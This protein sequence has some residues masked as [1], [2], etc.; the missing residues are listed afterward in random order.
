VGLRIRELSNTCW[1]VVLDRVCETCGRAG[2]LCGG[3]DFSGSTREPTTQAMRE[4]KRSTAAASP[5]LRE[6]II[7]I[8]HFCRWATRTR[9]RWSYPP[10]YPL[11]MPPADHGARNASGAARGCPPRVRTSHN[12]CC[13]L[14]RQP[15]WSRFP[16]AGVAAARVRPLAIQRGR[17][18]LWQPWRRPFANTEKSIISLASV[19][20][21]PLFR[22]P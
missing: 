19:A 21:L 2:V 8:Q 3:L 22:P 7:C 5:P 13:G 20:P 15:A 17:M 12:S 6:G 11:S 4:G 10:A 16:C 1:L 18:A 14:M 9:W